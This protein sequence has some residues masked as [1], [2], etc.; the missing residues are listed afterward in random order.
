MRTIR[1]ISVGSAFRI[2]AVVSGLLFAILGVFAV[3]LPGLFGASLLGVAVGREGAG[4]FGA[5]LV[6]SLIIY[7]LGI[8]L[9]ALLGGIFYAISAWLYNI[10]AGRV[11]GLE[12]EV[13]GTQ[14]PA[15]VVTPGPTL[16]GPPA[17][18]LGAAA[19][20]TAPSTAVPA[21][22]TPRSQPAPAAAAAQPAPPPVQPAGAT[23]Y[24]VNCGS[25][26]RPGV[27][28]CNQCGAAQA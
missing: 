17:T 4:V 1:R 26:L 3:L 9:Y 27:K 15:P 12:I 13:G 14:V 16:A 5:G 10:A 8:A 21:P 11:G 25:P 23:A 2:G 24:C 28:F 20:A 6:T 19:A 18:Q 7:L 22:P